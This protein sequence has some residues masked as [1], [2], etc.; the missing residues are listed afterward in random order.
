MPRQSP[1]GTQKYRLWYPGYT[2][3][4]VSTLAFVATGPGQTMTVSLFNTSLREAFGISELSLN[5]AYTIATVAAAF[6][7]VLVGR[8][9]DRLGVRLVMALIAVAFG[10]GCLAMTFA[11]GL[12]TVFLAFFLLRFLGQGSLAL[13]SQHAL[14][15]WF[16]RRLGTI[17]GIKQVLVFMI[18]IPFPPLTLWLIDEVGWRNAYVVFGIAIAAVITPL[19]L[20]FVRDK[21]EDLDLRVDND[22]EDD[23][24]EIAPDPTAVDPESA[25]GTRPRI[26]GFTLP[27]AMRTRA[28]W[29]LAACFFAPPLIGTAMLFDMQPILAVHGVGVEPAAA[30]TSAWITSMAV[31]AIPS[32]WLT[33]R[34]RP[35]A[36]LA[37]GMAL[38]AISSVALLMARSAFVASGA[39]ACFGAG[40]SLVAACAAA[41]VARYFGRANHGAIRSSLTR[42]GVVGTGLGP[43]FTGL[44]VEYAGAYEPA[45]WI[46]GAMCVPVMVAALGLTQPPEL[47]EPVGE[48]AEA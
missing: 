16:H 7:L 45:L 28:Y 31:M 29:T 32:G 6:P 5:T 27:Q 15:M 46:F 26:P 14:A 48:S 18:W 21:P 33:D 13:V 42:I 12:V 8:V 23:F 41:T 34:L 24:E 1:H 47:V 9:A 30:V 43:I 19:T 37:L 38:I 25:A 20:I 44:S 39:M 36:L 17:H 2:V 35:S 10:A 4:A 40:Q 11:Q 22:P 3:A